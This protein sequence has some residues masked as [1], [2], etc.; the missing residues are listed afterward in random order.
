MNTQL[1]FKKEILPKQFYLSKALVSSLHKFELP[2]TAKL[3]L[4]YL[5]DCY[6]PEKNEVF[7]KQKTIAEKI[8]L[9][10]RSVIRAIKELTT[11]G[12]IIYETKANNF[13]KFTSK[14][15][16]LANLSP[17]KGQNVTSRYDN[18]SH[19]YIGTDKVTE[20]EQQKK[21][22]EMS[23]KRKYHH[24]NHTKGMNYKTPEQTREEIKHTLVRDDK[25][26]MN[27]KDTAIKYIEELSPAE[28]EFV[29]A[30]IQRVKDKWGL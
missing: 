20:K 2:P 28:N 15:F 19:P 14:F 10:E 13:Y 21:V 23:E 9:S 25:S 30:Q 6:N 12:I 29:Q 1:N 22:F 4:I 17:E 24:E 8:G 7:P 16:S 3:V 11:A 26:P 5:A 18:L 27:D